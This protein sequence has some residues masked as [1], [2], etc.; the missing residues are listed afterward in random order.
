MNIAIFYRSLRRPGYLI[1]NVIRPL[2]IGLRTIFQMFFLYRI[3]PRLLKCYRKFNPTILHWA[4]GGFSKCFGGFLK[5]SSQDFFWYIV[6]H[7]RLNNRPSF[8]QS[9]SS[10]VRQFVS[11]SVRQFVS[12]SVHHSVSPSVRQSVSPSVRQFVSPSVRPPEFA[13][14]F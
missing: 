3:S 8:R 12:P 9:V 7:I 10:S 14:L 11:P 4:K 5:I 13:I 2:S 6:K 1:E